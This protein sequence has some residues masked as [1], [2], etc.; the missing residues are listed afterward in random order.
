MDQVSQKPSAGG[1]GLAFAQIG[2]VGPLIGLSF[3]I[4]LLNILTLTIYRFWGRTEV[5]RYLWG[6]T[7]INGEPLEYQ[8]TGLELFLGFLFALFL[9]LLPLYGAF[10][11]VT[12]FLAPTDPAYGLSILGLELVLV[13]LLGFGYYRAWRYRLSRT[14]WRGVRFSLAGNGHAYAR[15]ALMWVFLSI[16][17]LGLLYPVADARL[18]GHLLRDMRFGDRAFRFEGKARSLYLAFLI[19]FVLGVLIYGT[20]VGVIA[21]YMAKE[22]MIGAGET[23]SPED[24]QRLTIVMLPVLLAAGVLIGFAGC[25]YLSRRLRVFV[26]GLRLEGLTFSLHATAWSYLGLLF[27]NFLLIAFTLGF[28][29]PIA[30]L[31]TFRYMF[32][33]MTAEGSVDLAAIVQSGADQPKTGEGLAEAFGFGTV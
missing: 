2:R 28:A 4:L 33:R 26:G 15:R 6:S 10:Y 22:G 21:A 30:E 20:A 12:T 8:G 31:R 32:S 25:F 9:V 27:T 7:T 14:N 5:R 18:T 3:K 16:V 19:T 1:E 13:Y 23:P 24:I 17:S 11:G 29:M